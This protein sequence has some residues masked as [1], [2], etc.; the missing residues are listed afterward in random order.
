MGPGRLPLASHLEKGLGIPSTIPL[1]VVF[2]RSFFLLSAVAHRLASD[3]LSWMDG[4]EEDRLHSPGLWLLLMSLCVCLLLLLLFL[5]CSGRLPPCCQHPCF[6]PATSAAALSSPC[7]LLC[8]IF[9]IVAH[10]I[11]S[12]PLLP[13]TC[14]T[15]L[16]VSLRQCYDC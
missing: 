15:F 11:S 3:L 1:I 14:S 10:L 6:L 12:V 13:S 4:R 8:S 5:G 16:P 9:L 7:L 2:P